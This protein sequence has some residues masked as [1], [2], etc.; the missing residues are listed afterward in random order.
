M[1]CVRDNHLPPPPPLAQGRI[2]C[3]SSLQ[4]WD[5]RP[6]PYTGDAGGP[7]SLPSRGVCARVCR[8]YRECASLSLCL[9]RRYGRLS[10]EQTSV[11]IASIVDV[12]RAIIDD[13]DDWRCDLSSAF[14][15]VINLFTVVVAARA[16]RDDDDFDSDND[17]KFTI[18]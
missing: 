16:R 8:Q 10:E 12:E 3:F 17:A 13:S 18:E 14:V 11:E 5:L 2:F 9:R 7:A 4:S 15:G 6:S 1:T